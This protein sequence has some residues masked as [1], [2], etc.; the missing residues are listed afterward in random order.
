MDD[1]TRML[2]DIYKGLWLS[3]DFECDLEM[4]FLSQ[5][6]MLIRNENEISNNDLISMHDFWRECPYLN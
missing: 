3:A 5:F 2:M 6:K 1:R 4:E